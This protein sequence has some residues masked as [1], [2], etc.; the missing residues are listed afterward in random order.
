MQTKTSWPLV[1]IVAGAGFTA[2]FNIGK[3]AP[4]LP[5][6]QVEMGL[7][8]SDL[9]LVASVYSLLSMLLCV[10]IAIAGAQFGNYRTAVLA[11]GL[12]GCG[13][14]LS[15]HADNLSWLLFGRIVEGF[16]FVM[17]AVA[18]PALI[19][20]AV[21]PQDRAMGMTVWSLW[22]PVGVSAMLLI[23]P[24]LIDLADWRLPW[25]L[26][27]WFS[28]FWMLVV[29]LTFLNVGRAGDKQR[30][31]TKQ[32]IMG[33]FQPGTLMMALSIGLFS[34][35]YTVGIAFSP[36]LWHETKQISL[37]TGSYL[38][39]VA[40]F[41]TVIGNFIGGYFIKRGYPLNRLLVIGFVI[42]SLLCS[43]VFVQ[44]LP[45]WLQYLCF[46]IFTT[47]VGVIPAA[48]FAKAP[49][50]TTEPIQIS[51][52]IALVF[53]GTTAGQV[54]GPIVFSHLIEWKNGDWSWGA[55][56][57]LSIAVMGGLVMYSIKPPKSA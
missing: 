12:M 43:L 53:Q 33:I 17:I 30:G 46:V 47:S 28:L 24:T 38:L 36:T 48:I 23:S 44:A 6:I 35:L 8:L 39:A 20:R 19:A 11:L 57:V 40:I 51:L 4:V 42:P 5:L 45:F 41:C 25:S 34:S 56:Y 15:A 3:V 16:G 26:T 49:A 31:I 37:Q 9:G 27:G 29:T 14:L 2:A 32:Q 21:L 54:I 18:G 55:V 13:G 10:P 7:E 22:L 50:Y 52:A 1:M